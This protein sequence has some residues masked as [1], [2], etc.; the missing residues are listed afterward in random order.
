MSDQSYIAAAV[1]RAMK[2][3][4][5]TLRRWAQSRGYSPKTVYNVVARWGHRRDRG[6]QGVISHEIL[7][8]LKAELGPAPFAPPKSLSTR[9]RQAA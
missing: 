8:A 5:T 3:R 2:Q 1:K 6:P 4:G 9:G 7:G